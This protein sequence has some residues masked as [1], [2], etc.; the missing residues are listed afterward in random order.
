MGKASSSKKVARAARAG[1]RTKGVRQRNL[2]FPAAI[3]FIIV[4]GAALVGFAWNDRRDEAASEPPVA[5]VDHWHAAFGFNTCGEWQPNLPEFEVP[6]GTHTHADGVIHIHPFAESRSGDNATLSN[7][8][9]DAGVTLTDSELRIGEDE[10]VEGETECDGEPGEIVVAQWLDVENTED[11]PALITENFDD[12]R[13]RGDGEGYTIAFVP[14]GQTD[15][16]PKPESAANLASLGA[17][18]T[19]AA[20]Q[21]DAATSTSTPAEGE[22]TTTAPGTPAPEGETTTTAAAPPAGETATTAAAG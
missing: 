9:D 10:W 4:L 18:D 21:Q 19:G 6:G 16:I 1:G 2:G 17:A 3:V 7:F 11:P 20:T 12:I 8:L 14:E 22:T 5:N 13:F 15:D